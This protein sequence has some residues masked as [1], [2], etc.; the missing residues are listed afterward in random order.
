MASCKREAVRTINGFCLN[1]RIIFM[2]RF[3]VYIFLPL[4]PKRKKMEF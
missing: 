2:K 1:S 4:K 3:R